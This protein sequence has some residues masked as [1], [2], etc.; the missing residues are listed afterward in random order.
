MKF[1]K[2]SLFFVLIG[3]CLLVTISCCD[4]EKEES[5]FQ[6]T[7]LTKNE[8]HQKFLEYYKQKKK[9]LS[10]FFR[11][12][13]FEKIADLYHKDAII[14]SPEGNTFQGRNLITGFWQALS[15]RGIKDVTFEIKDIHIVDLIGDKAAIEVEKDDYDYI[16]YADAEIT[17]VTPEKKESEKVSGANALVAPHRADCTFSIIFEDQR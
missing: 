10:E 11:A 15:E 3:F 1:G 2:H 8:I 5:S 4:K 7:K 6:Y 17:F 13:E 9:Q 16:V 14:I 12:G